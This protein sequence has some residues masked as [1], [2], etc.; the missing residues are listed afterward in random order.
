MT[1]KAVK[2]VAESNPKAIN[3]KPEEFMD[4]SYMDELDKNGFIKKVWQ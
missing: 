1:P 3:R 4:L 2:L